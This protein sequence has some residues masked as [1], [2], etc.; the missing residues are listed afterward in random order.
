MVQSQMQQLEENGP[1]SSDVHL[2]LAVRVEMRSLVHDRRTQLRD[3]AAH[4]LLDLAVERA[5]GGKS[6]QR[7]RYLV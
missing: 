7:N 2:T 5:D 4:R 3:P 6:A 1:Q